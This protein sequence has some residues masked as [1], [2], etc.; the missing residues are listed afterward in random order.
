MFTVFTALFSNQRYK[1]LKLHFFSGPKTSKKVKQNNQVINR[2]RKYRILIRRRYLEMQILGGIAWTASKVGI[3]HTGTTSCAVSNA[4]TLGQTRCVWIWLT[5]HLNSAQKKGQLWGHQAHIFEHFAV[6]LPDL[7]LGNASHFTPKTW[8]A[9]YHF[10]LT[11]KNQF[12][13]L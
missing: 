7:F 10:Y 6:G 8:S 2:G 4:I 13:L 3:K 12:D 5:F 11:I 9:I 1:G